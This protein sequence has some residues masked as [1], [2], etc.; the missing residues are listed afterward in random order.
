MA[1]RNRI[2]RLSQ[3]IADSITGAV[4]STAASGA[5]WVLQSGANANQIIGY[6]GSGNEITPGQ[7]ATAV[8]GGSGRLVL[9]GPQVNGAGGVAPYINLVDDIV[10]GNAI[11]LSTKQLLIGSGTLMGFTVIQGPPT[12]TNAGG[13][14]T[15]LNPLVDD[16]GN[17]VTPKWVMCHNTAAG[18]SA[19][20]CFVTG[21]NSAQYVVTVRNVS[22][23][24]IV[25]STSVSL[26][27]LLFA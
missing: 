2:V 7:I 12:S 5:R 22:D 26:H 14:I 19:H 23:G 21:I 24:S 17:A 13:Q 6:S 18:G 25:A 15:F 11:Q 8:T 16:D 4:I 10:S 3:L 27:H 20:V 9:T 1:F